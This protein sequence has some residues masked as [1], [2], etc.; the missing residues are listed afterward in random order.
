[1]R[2]HTGIATRIEGGIQVTHATVRGYKPGSIITNSVGNN[3]VI[4]GWNYPFV[5]AGRPLVIDKTK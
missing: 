5:G 3:G 2:Y 4:S 1:M